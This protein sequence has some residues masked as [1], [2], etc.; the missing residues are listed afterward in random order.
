MRHRH[1]IP[2]VPAIPRPD[3]AFYT[4]FGRPRVEEILDKRP[5]KPNLRR[6]PCAELAVRMR[7][8][9]RRCVMRRRGFYDFHLELHGEF[10]GW[11]A[12]GVVTRLIL[13]LPAKFVLPRQ[14]AGHRPDLH[15]QIEVSAIHAQLLIGCECK[16]AF[17]ARRICDL[18]HH[19]IGW[20]IQPQSCRESDNRRSACWS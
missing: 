13:Q 10:L 18:A 9:R 17:L 16:T 3:G 11:I 19:Q 12:S 7:T 14:H 5:W 4:D 8:L 2:T 20:R 15:G 6:C 1:H